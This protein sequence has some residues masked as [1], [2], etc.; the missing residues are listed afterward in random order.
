MAADA[1]DDVLSDAM[2]DLNLDFEDVDEDLAPESF[3]CP[4]THELMKNPVVACD[5]CAPAL[6]PGVAGIDEKRPYEGWH[7][8][9][10]KVLSA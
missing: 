3:C 10:E 8:G 9:S 4:I 7:L 1:G 5:G 6:A 2:E